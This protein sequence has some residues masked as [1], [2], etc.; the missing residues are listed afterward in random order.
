MVWETSAETRLSPSE[1]LTMTTSTPELEIF[2]FQWKHLNAYVYKAACRVW[3]ADVEID[4]WVWMGTWMIMYTS[5]PACQSVLFSQKRKEQVKLPAA[6]FKQK[7]LHIKLVSCNK[8]NK[9]SCVVSTIIE[10][11]LHP[12]LKTLI[13]CATSLTGICSSVFLQKMFSGW[14]NFFW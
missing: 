9:V 5:N 2:T 7:L 8:T 4:N 6:T 12:F 1:R 3:I 14:F 13:L 11:K 10:L